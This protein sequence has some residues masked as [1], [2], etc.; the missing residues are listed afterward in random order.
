MCGDLSRRGGGAGDLHPHRVGTNRDVHRSSTTTTL[1]S[2]SFSTS[3]T[4][5]P[6]VA[7]DVVEDLLLPVGILSVVQH[8]RL[9]LRGLRFGG[10]VGGWRER[11][12]V[13]EVC[14]R[15]TRSIMCAIGV[16]IQ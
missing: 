16:V 3:R 14:E 2:P 8:L 11:E 12:R 10:F 6:G 15:K 5:D 13:S 7:V 1:A 9:A 4:S